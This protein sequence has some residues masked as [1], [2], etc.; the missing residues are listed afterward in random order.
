MSGKEIVKG[1]GTGT[2]AL[3]GAAVGSLFGRAAVF[4]GLI[5]G[6]GAPAAIALGVVGTVLG[7]LA[8]AAVLGG[9][10]PS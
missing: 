8:G 3:A 6:V 1:A 10:T 2:G 7:A 4:A 9:S 5:P